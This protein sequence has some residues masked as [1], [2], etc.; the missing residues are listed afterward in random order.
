MKNFRD[1]NRQILES[2]ALLLEHERLVREVEVQNQVYIT[3][4]QQHEMVKI[5]FFDNTSMLEV[6]D[7]PELPL[8]DSRTKLSVYIIA[9][10]IFSVFFSS[11]FIL[12]VDWYSS[13]SADSS[14]SA[15][16]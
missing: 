10:I 14:I 2:P 6:L 3:M 12:I 5:E 4:K 15:N 8:A 1:K 7:E 9:A 11:A 13:I 16:N